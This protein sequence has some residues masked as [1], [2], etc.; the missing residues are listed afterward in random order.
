MDKQNV[1]KLCTEL[2][3]RSGNVFREPLKSQM[4]LDLILDILSG[5]S[6]MEIFKKY[7]N[8]ENVKAIRREIFKDLV[9]R[10]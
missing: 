3:A 4:I 2:F 8:I 1:R 9:R 7:G 6:D 10:I 5:M